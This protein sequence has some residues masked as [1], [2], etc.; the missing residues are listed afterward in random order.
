MQANWIYIGE[1]NEYSKAH[2]EQ[3]RWDSSLYQTWQQKHAKMKTLVDVLFLKNRERQGAAWKRLSNEEKDNFLRWDIFK[4]WDAITTEFA[5]INK[6]FMEKMADGSEN[7]V[8]RHRELLA[9]PILK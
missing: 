3:Y 8:E 6:L 5:A 4:K 1:V 7:L 2:V 9:Y